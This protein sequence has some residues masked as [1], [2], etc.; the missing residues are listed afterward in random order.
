M[1]LCIYLFVFLLELF[2]DRLREVELLAQRVNIYAI[3]LDSSDIPLLR[4]RNNR[5]K[6]ASFVLSTTDQDLIGVSAVPGM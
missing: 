2:W 3:L 6:V 1:A 4:K 5:L